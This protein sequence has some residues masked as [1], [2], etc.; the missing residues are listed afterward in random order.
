MQHDKKQHFLT[1]MTAAFA[2]GF[3]FFA[4]GSPLTALVA[5]SCFSA[6]LALGKEYGDS[7]AAGNKWDWLDILADA[8]GLIVGVLPYILLSIILSV[9]GK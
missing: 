2:A 1:C 3:P 9:G 8:G 7:K 4:I 6:G 5:G